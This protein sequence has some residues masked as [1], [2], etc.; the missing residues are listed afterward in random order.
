MIT[1]VTYENKTYTERD[2]QHPAMITR[3]CACGNILTIPVAAWVLGLVT[4]CGHCH[5]NNP[6]PAK[7]HSAAIT[8]SYKELIADGGIVEL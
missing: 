8:Q 6:F 2:N 5:S 1:T 4:D 7:N 3:A